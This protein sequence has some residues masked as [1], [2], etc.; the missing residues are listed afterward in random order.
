MRLHL[1]ENPYGPPAGALEAAADELRRWGTAYP[2]S[3]CA[4]PRKAVADHFGLTPEMVAVGNG[5]DELVLLI[6]LA[7]L[8]PGD[9][10]LL[11]EG[12]YLGYAM[13]AAAARA[14]VRTEPLKR[15]GVPARALASALG[16]GARLCYVCNPHNPTGTVLDP[17][18]VERIIAAA[19]NTGAVPVFDEAYMEFADPAYDYAL[20]AVRKGRRL[21]VLR[22]FSKAWG[23]AS[24]RC[25]Y[26]LGPADLIDQ[27]WR[28]RQALPFSANRLAQRAA[29]AA[30]GDRGHLA[31]IRRLTGEAR[32][33]MC[34]RLDRAGVPHVP[35]VTNF[36]MLR[37]P[38][39]SALV[40][41]RLAEEHRILVRDVTM[42]GLPG[43]LRVSVGTPEQVDVFCSALEDVLGSEV[44]TASRPSANSAVPVVPPQAPTLAP[45]DPATL[46][47][48]YV[49]AGVIHA[50]GELGVWDLLLDGAATP[51]ALAKRT[52]ADPDGLLV[53]LKTMALLGHVTMTADSAVALTSA[54]R[55]LVRN[56]GYFTWCVGGYGEVLHNLA[57]LTTGRRSL[58]RDVIRHGDKI[59]AGSGIT[60]RNLMLPV[61]REVVSGLEF[62]LVADLGCGDAA[63]LIRW[64][65]KDTGRRGIGFEAD[66]EA[67]R[68][69]VEH[70]REAG[71]EDRLEIVHGDVLSQVGQ[72]TY[73][74]VD[75]VS[76]FLMMH[77]LFNA[78]GDPVKAI[79]LLHH[80]F[81]DARK[82]LVADSVSQDWHSHEGPLPIFSLG[83]EL[84]HAFMDTHIAERD[85]YE[86]A[87][88]RAGLRIDRRTPF[89]TP[90]T[91]LWLL[92]S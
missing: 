18:D 90:A 43:H 38:G 85:V 2:D 66:E 92:T 6:A 26:A 47:N 82:F 45:L 63:R 35:S 55:E 91:Y 28:V 79:R 74:G 14:E 81:P 30:L 17:S 7:F 62:D 60:G 73:P 10:V 65:A 11:T 80:V 21:L 56:R 86:D 49:G 68:S 70:V 32:Q 84:V 39:D 12:T 46:F 4:G 77:D 44:A 9:T 37:P 16:E 24:L 83:F 23:L 67:H 75:L 42:L 40:A 87:F 54:G 50:L 58:G 34:D 72:R 76:S 29:M 88:T 8:R 48:G 51:T 5:S 36:V 22:T 57:D 41:A 3:D 64:C 53:L 27:V 52:G 33:R 61:E 59:A 1:N 89:G 19:E 15:F 69:A 78:T 20:D 71:L 13:A 25:G 31:E